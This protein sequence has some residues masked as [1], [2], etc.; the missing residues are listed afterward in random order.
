MR[1]RPDIELE[2][3]DADLLSIDHHDIA[4]NRRVDRDRD[5]HR[6]LHGLG[7]R[8]QPGDDRGFDRCEQCARDR[9]APQIDVLAPPR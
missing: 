2:R 3:R 8:Q 1:G 9:D 5:D 7:P 6:G 4:R